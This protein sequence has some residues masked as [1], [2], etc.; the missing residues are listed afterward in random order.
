MNGRR[1]MLDSDAI[2]TRLA[3]GGVVLMATDTVPGLHARLD[4]P[5]A[6]EELRIIKGR[7]Q[8][9]PLLL[10]AASTQQVLQLAA[11]LPPPTA[12]FLAA[13]WPGPFTFILP[14]AEGLPACVT[15]RGAARAPSEPGMRTASGRREPPASPTATVAVRVPAWDALRA[16][17]R[18]SGP[19]ASSSA[20]RASEP[21][22]AD[23]AAAMA[24]LP[25]L[26]VWRGTPDHPSGAPSALV[27]LTGKEPAV[28]RCGPLP[29]PDWPS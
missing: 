7:A 11:D 17:L 19:L 27:D 28:L 1:T 23:L 6:L 13:C 26:P 15:A 18:E 9:K 24:L 3:A 10:L 29:L 21:A 16:L 4:R 20:N 12:E 8:G 22:P 25:G 5:A 2:L 14:A